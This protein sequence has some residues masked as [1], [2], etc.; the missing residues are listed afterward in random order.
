MPRVVLQAEVSLV[1]QSLLERVTDREKSKAVFVLQIR[2]EKKKLKWRTE[3]TKSPKFPFFRIQWASRGTF[4]THK[5][6][7]IFRK[8]S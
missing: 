5:H 2:F 6:V 1:G 3:D 8:F 4:N 7:M